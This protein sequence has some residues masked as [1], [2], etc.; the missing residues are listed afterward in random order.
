MSLWRIIPH[1]KHSYFK[2]EGGSRS[3]CHSS[4]ESTPCCE[5]PGDSPQSLNTD[6]LSTTSSLGSIVDQESTGSPDCESGLSGEVNGDLQEN[7][8]PEAFSVLEAPEPVPDLLSEDDRTEI[9]QRSPAGE[10][11][12]HGWGLC[13]PL[14]TRGDVEGGEVTELEGEPRPVDSGP[15]SR[16]SPCQDQDSLA[17][18]QE[19]A[20]WEP[21]DPQCMLPEASLLD[22]P[23]MPS[24]PSWAP[25]AEGRLLGTGVNIGGAKETGGEQDLLMPMVAPDHLGSDPWHAVPD[26]DTGR[27]AVVASEC[28][29]GSVGGWLTPPVCASAVGAQDPRPGHSSRDQVLTSSD[30]EDIYAQGLPSSSSETSVVELGGSHCLQDLS[31]PADDDVGALKSDQ[32]RGL[33]L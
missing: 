27:R 31:Q 28:D 17:E 25:S 6:L 32:V 2:L 16:Q 18:A 13:L 8:D 7:H 3:A 21:E 26:D 4:L 5:F 24:S 15:R 20:G 9:P 29:L 33:H 1:F 23:P 11:E 12:L 10:V 19:E 14:H 30:E 22:L